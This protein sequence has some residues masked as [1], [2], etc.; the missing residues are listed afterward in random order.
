M[1]VFVVQDN[2]CAHTV[3]QNLQWIV[4]GLSHWR[5]VQILMEVEYDTEPA[6]PWRNEHSAFHSES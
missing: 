3:G 6:E 1:T 2:K 4:A 5:A